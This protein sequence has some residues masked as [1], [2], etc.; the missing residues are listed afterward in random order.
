MLKTA[1]AGIVRNLKHWNRNLHFLVNETF[2][3][4]LLHLRL[5]FSV[6][7]NAIQITVQNFH[8]YFQQFYNE[9]TH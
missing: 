3:F 2:Y 5:A 9:Q 7:G 8:K 1:S 6:I 4:Q